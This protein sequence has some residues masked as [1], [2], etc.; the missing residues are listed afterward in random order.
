MLALSEEFLR[1]IGDGCCRVHGG[2]FAGTI[3]CVLPQD[4]LAAYR[5]YMAQFVAPEQIYPLQIRP[6]GAV[7][8]DPAL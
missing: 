8:L 5:A 3:L 7:R 2:G 4:Q 6:Y 1:Q